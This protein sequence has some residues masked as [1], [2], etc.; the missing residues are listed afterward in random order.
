LASPINH[1]NKKVLVFTAFADTANYLYEHLANQLL[2]SHRIHSG[3]VTGSDAPKST[4]KR[5]LD[6][7]SLLTLFSP[8][9]KEKSKVL[10]DEPGEIDLLIG[11]DCISEGQNLQDC[12]TV[13]N[14]DIH[15]NPVRI[16]QRFGRID[17]IGSPN[18]SIQLVNYWPDISL[19]EYI[20]LKERVENRMV[21]ADVT[22]TG[23]DNP[24]NQES[25]DIAY[26]KEQLRRLQDEVI[27]MEDVK[28]GISITDLGLNDFRM[29]LLNHV[30]EHGALNN[31]PNGMHAVVAAD[32]DRGL[33]PGV[34]FTLRNRNQG[35]NINQLN[36][37]HPFY[38]VYVAKDGQIVSNH[39]EVKRLL[40]LARTACKGKEEPVHSV[41][42]IFNEATND[43]REMA[44]YSDLLDKAIQSMV[45]I[46]EER[47]IDSLF[48]GGRTSALIDKINGLDDFELISFLVIQG[49]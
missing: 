14:Y 5:N 45:A 8:R 15:W 44:F 19:D 6:F 26:R 1:G 47:D 9:S 11:T 42:K 33:P 43:G 16:I 18:A 34:I 7:Q 2:K 41:C 38:L 35:V 13:I 22:A 17:R 4:L 28:T 46:K 40:D 3:R 29:D 12:D 30:K 10:P 36:R 25:N 32:P 27:E 23:D 49:K 48:S 37:L 24:L 21:I 31:L 39:T 20:K